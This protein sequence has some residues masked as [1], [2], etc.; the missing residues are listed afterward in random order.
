MEEIE[1]IY[2]HYNDTFKIIKQNEKKRDRLFIVLFL[3][4]LLL[5]LCSIMPNTIYSMIQEFV[6]DKT[7]ITLSFGFNI[8]QSFLWITI[9]YTTVKYFQV[10]V[11]INRSYT[12]LHDIEMQINKNIKFKFQREGKQYMD[13]YPLLLDY[14]YQM[15]ITVFPILY[16]LIISY[17]IVLEWLKFQY[18]YNTIFNTIIYGFI[19]III[20]LY[21][22]VLHPKNDKSKK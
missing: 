9:F 11:H 19:L 2:D 1:L 22:I 5:F 18:I 15:Y 16:A 3:L 7:D 12:Y 13:N 8:I 10:V 21:Y 6:K 4:V 20:I 17:K 14:I